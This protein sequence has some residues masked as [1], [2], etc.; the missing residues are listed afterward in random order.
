MRFADVIGQEG[1]K[2]QLVQMVQTN[3]IS[4]A[5][6][7]LARE[8]RGGLPMA[9]AFAQYIMCERIQNGAETIEEGDDLFGDLAPKEPADLS[10]S[11]GNCPSCQ[12]AQEMIHPDVHYSFPVF[13]RKAGEK[14]I[15]AYFLPQF[16]SFVAEHPYSNLFDWLQYIKAENKQGNITATECEDILHKLSLKSFESGYKIL[17]MWMPEQLGKIGNKLLKIIEEPPEKT[18]FI[19]VAE[20][21]DDILQTILSR[22]QL[23]KLPPLRAEAIENALVERRKIPVPQAKTISKM[24]EGNYHQAELQSTDEDH[25]YTAMLREWLNAVIQTSPA[26][27]VKWVD[28]ISKI[29]REQQKQFCK[30]FIHLL[31]QA[32]LLQTIPNA[33]DA[34]DDNTFDF[35]RRINKFASIPQQDAIIQELEKATY[36]IERNANPKILFHAL[37]I[38]LFHIIKNNSVILVS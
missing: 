8:G 22:T 37:T 5:Q 29:G 18:L 27:Q 16:R 38:K 35:A 25:N 31:Q 12:K 14:P 1:T 9:L 7:F 28:M 3:R 30:Y 23:I 33:Q 15:S 17:I 19:F 11:C 6:L 4:H 34:M 13:P 24:A 32:I 36:Y 2:A 10:D 20:R 26:S 21:E